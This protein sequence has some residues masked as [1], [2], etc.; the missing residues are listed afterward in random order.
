MYHPNPKGGTRRISRGKLRTETYPY[1]PRNLYR[2]L[3]LYS[4]ALDTPSTREKERERGV[5]SR[6]KSQELAAY[7]FLLCVI[8]RHRITFSAGMS[9]RNSILLGSLQ[10]FPPTF[11][12]AIHRSSLP[13]GLSRDK[14]FEFETKFLHRRKELLAGML[15]C[16]EILLP[17]RLPIFIKRSFVTKSD[18][19][20]FKGDL[21][22]L[23]FKARVI[24]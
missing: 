23:I 11:R 10:E 1:C 17:V 19:P 21:G 12:T 14:R 13:R 2:I 16:T 20:W 8:A 22:S 5:R 18:T 4:F 7:E 6:R 24:S 9:L 15:A 3:Y